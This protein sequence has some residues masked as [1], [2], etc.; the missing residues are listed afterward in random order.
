MMPLHELTDILLLTGKWHVQW[1]EVSRHCLISR[2]SPQSNN[3]G[4]EGY[5]L[6]LALAP[7]YLGPVDTSWSI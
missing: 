7:Y 2:Q 5:W 6:G 3:L 4:L 1:C